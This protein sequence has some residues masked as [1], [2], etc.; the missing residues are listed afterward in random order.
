MNKNIFL[1]LLVFFS[2]SSLLSAN[3]VISPSPLDLETKVNNQKNFS[4]TISNNYT[5]DILDFSFPILENKGFIFPN[6]SI[7]QNTTNTYQISV[8][9]NESFYGTLSELVEFKFWVDLPEEVTTHNIK[10]TEYGFS[11][12]YTTIRKG[13]IVQ[14]E[15]KDTI[16]HIIKST[17]F[18]SITINPNQTSVFTFNNLGNMFYYDDFWGDFLEF[19]GVIEV[20]ERTE[21][22]KAHNPN[23]DYLWSIN[24]N[25]IA[26]LTNLSVTNSENKYEI[27]NLN[28]KKGLI[29]IK[30]IGDKKAE[31]IKL[32]SDSSWI[33]F[34]QNN[35]DLGAGDTEWVEYT[36]LPRVYLTNDTDKNYTIEI[37]AKAFNTNQSKFNL[38]V[39]VPYK[40]I[41]DDITSSV[42]WGEYLRLI[43][44]VELP[45]SE[46]CHP[47][48]PECNLESQYG[49]YSNLLTFNGTSYDLYDIKRDLGTTKNSVLRL[50]NERKAWELEYGD[51]INKIASDSN[52]SLQ[53]GIE[54]A[55][56]EK[57]RIAFVWT[58]IFIIGIFGM[59]VVL[60]IRQN[61]IDNKKNITGEQYKYRQ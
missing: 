39:Y 61:K 48:L 11:E 33:I 24:L 22:Q 9:T 6:I 32:E 40:K 57:K 1:A 52:E 34:D 41:T 35:F 55:K 10:I 49:N 23:Y 27:E 15:N 7:P 4:I 37:T 12:T 31:G 60:I 20:V 51:K 46:L 25:S 58:V 59:V 30:N 56:K 53:K 50:E 38:S 5:F 43:F 13:D 8:K 28:S 17:E 2:L 47:E 45:C 21:Q 29:T 42:G 18:G 26:E 44:C 19:Q 54:N 14:W 36:I 3:L 16:S